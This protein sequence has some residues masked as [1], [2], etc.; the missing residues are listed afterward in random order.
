[1]PA[2]TERQRRD[3]RQA[4]AELKNRIRA[5]S[6]PDAVAVAKFRHAEDAQAFAELKN[7]AAVRAGTRIVHHWSEV[8]AALRSDGRMRF[9]VLAR[10]AD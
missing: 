7:R 5:E 3:Q 10:Y 9:A 6:A 8:P 2:L 4:F 1:M